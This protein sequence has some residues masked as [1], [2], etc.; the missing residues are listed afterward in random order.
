M[1]YECPSFTLDSTHT[2]STLSETKT[3]NRKKRSKYNA[4]R[5]TYF[6]FLWPSIVH[7]SQGQSRIPFALSSL[8]IIENKG[9]S[10]HTVMEDSLSAKI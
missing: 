1:K 9:P 4:Y 6:I 8:R 7:S 2:F 10:Q 3:E 5:D